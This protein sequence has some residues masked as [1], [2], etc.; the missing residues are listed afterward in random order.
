MKIDVVKGLISI[1]IGALLAYACYEICNY[2]AL[3]WVITLGAFI[4]ISVPAFMALGISSKQER[5]AVVLAILSWT[6]LF[7]EIVANS[8]FVFFDFSV[9]LYVVV[10]GVMLLLYTCIYYSIYKK[11][12]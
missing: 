11:K 7:V 1:A 8:I 6:I 4:T 5:S 10:N 12:M 9:P 3:K 2:E